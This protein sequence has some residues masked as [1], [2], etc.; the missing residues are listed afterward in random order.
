MIQ[1]NG[2]TK[3]YGNQTAL[4]GISLEIGDGQVIGVLGENGAGKTTLLKVLAGLTSLDDGEITY[5]DITTVK[6]RSEKIAFMTEEGSFFPFMTAKENA[7]FLKDYYPKFD[8]ERFEKLC[9]FLMIPMDKKARAFSKGQ[10]AKLEIALGF[11]KGAKYLLIDEPFLGNDIFTRRNFLKLMCD[12]LITDET[13]VIATHMIDE[14]ENF[15]DRAVLLENG[16]LIR[17]VLIEEMQSNHQSL[18]ELMKEA[19]HYDEDRFRSIFYSG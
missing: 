17:D 8:M 2:I 16:H 13:I 18:E 7:L 15:I 10:K 1:I 9:D 5:F 4:K 12:S 14:I 3:R 6:E 19:F 11:S